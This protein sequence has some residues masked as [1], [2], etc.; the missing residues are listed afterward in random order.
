MIDD[1][2][3]YFVTSP[4]LRM[5][6]LPKAAY[7]GNLAELEFYKSYFAKPRM[8]EI[9][10]VASIVALASDE[11]ERNGMGAMDALHVAAASL[12]EAEELYTLERSDK[13][14]YRTALVRVLSLETRA[15]L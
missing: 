5:E 3:R 15:S 11:A 9:N 2:D 12:A 13:P 1:L 10:D 14:M 4:F 7:Y 8:I 6:T